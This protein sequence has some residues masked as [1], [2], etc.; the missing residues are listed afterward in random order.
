MGQPAADALNDLW[1]NYL[2]E[3]VSSTINAAAF[4]L[5]VWKLD[6]D[7]AIGASGF[8]LTTGHL[9]A[10]SGVAG[11][12]FA[13]AQAWLDSI[14]PS[15]GDPLCNGHF[16]TCC[17]DWFAHCARDGSFP[18]S[19]GG[20]YSA[21]LGRSARTGVADRMGAVSQFDWAGSC[22]SLRMLISHVGVCRR[23]T[24][25]PAVF[26]RPFSYSRTILLGHTTTAARV[27][28]AVSYFFP[29]SQRD[30]DQR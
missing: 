7:Q 15:G 6:Y 29:P 28:H 4:Q 1:T 22:P 18:G 10:Q 9:V 12:V 24:K 17:T 8:D 23:S 26:R 5:A 30:L 11:T 25:G 21:W 3:A 20:N 14:N 2:D 19:T 16:F 27:Y 13:I